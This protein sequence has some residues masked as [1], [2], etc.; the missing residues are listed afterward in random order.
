MSLWQKMMAAS[1]GE[2]LAFMS[3][4]PTGETRIRDIQGARHL[5]TFNGQ[6]VAGMLRARRAG[7]IP[8]GTMGTLG[9]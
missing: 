2:P 9:Q 7:A 4:H 5:S 1:R 3:T 8:L 6:T